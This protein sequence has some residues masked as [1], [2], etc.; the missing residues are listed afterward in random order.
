MLDPRR[1][2]DQ[3]RDW[4]DWAIVVI[5]AC[6]GAAS[7]ALRLWPTIVAMVLVALAAAD[8]LRRRRS[9]RSE[10]SPQP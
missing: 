10:V 1:G 7:V 5:A 8:R 9:T 4:A 3:L 6:F 2:D